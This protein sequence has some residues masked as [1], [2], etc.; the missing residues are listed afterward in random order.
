MLH[1]CIST[2][3][4]L[5]SSPFHFTKFYEL[6][7]SSCNI[8]DFVQETSIQISGRDTNYPHL[9]I[10]VCLSPSRQMLGSTSKQA[11]TISF[12]IHCNSLF[13]NNFVTLCY[14]V[15]AIVNVFK[16]TVNKKSKR[17]MTEVI[18]KFCTV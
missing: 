2:D 6:L 17:T 14:I 12:H 11:T 4:W 13:N 7:G 9:E 10:L 8:S 1:R 3:E 15:L 16:Q 18:R 5:H